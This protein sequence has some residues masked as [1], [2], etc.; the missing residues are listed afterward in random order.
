MGVL[1][2]GHSRPETFNDNTERILYIIANQVALAVYNSHLLSLHKKQKSVL[3]HSQDRYRSLVEQVNDLLDLARLE[4]GN[5]QFEKKPVRIR[6]ILTG[7]RPNYKPALR[8]KKIRMQ[9]QIP[10]RIPTF[11]GDVRKINQALCILVESAIRSTPEHGS[12]RL[13]VALEDVDPQRWPK[14]KIPSSASKFLLFS[15]SDTAPSIPQQLHGTI[16]EKLQHQGAES[17]SSRGP[18]LSL[19]LAKEIIESHKGQIW[20]ESGE[21]QGNTYFFTLPIL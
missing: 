6:E 17:G 10:K 20:L 9:V 12:I 21:S 5:L 3:E 1:S 13:Q 15:L 4:T 18:S 11:L 7:I 14:L 8:D 16:F 19:Y 2:I